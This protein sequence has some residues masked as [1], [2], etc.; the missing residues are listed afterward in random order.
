MSHHE[1]PRWRRYLRFW[2]PD[3][4]AD[5]DDEIRFHLEMLERDFLAAGLDPAAAREEALARFGDPDEVA[6][7]LRDHDT[8]KLR[9]SGAHRC[10]GDLLQDVRY[11]LRRL[12]Q[13]PGV[14]ARGRAGARA[15]HRRH[16]R[17]LRR[18]RRRA[19]ARAPVSRARASG[20]GRDLQGADPVPASFPEYHDWKGQYGRLRRA[21]RVLHHH[22]RADRRAASRSCCTRRGCRRTCRGCSAS[23]RASDARSRRPRTMP[24]PEGVVMIS[25]DL[26]RRRFGGDP[27][28]IGT[29]LTLAEEPYTVI[30]IVPRRPALD[31]ADRPARR[32]TA[33]RP[34]AVRCGSTT[35]DAPRGLHFLD[36][37]RA[38]SPALD[39]GGPQR[40]DRVVCAP[41]AGGRGDRPRHPARCA[42][43][44]R[45]RRIAA[46]PLRPRRR[47]GH[48]APHR[49]HQRGEPAARALGGATAR[50]R[51]PR[52][53]GRG[54]ARAWCGSCW[55]RACCSR[56]WAAPPACWSHGAP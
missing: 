44:P 42:G 31:R 14:H 26:W 48:A 53:A 36:V 35:D 23:C 51:R 24:R 41:A 25:E 43:S 15:R 4:A 6:R 34:L 37:S 21:R 32:G 16:D 54:R 56:C 52:G 47:R 29:T 38:S 33:S 17:D 50:D 45:G 9:R 10:A 46:P 3:V 13:A 5:V 11:G 55:S 49:V 39:L 8:R 7:W 30:G 12:W 28:I 1:Q 19:A 20:G 27:G 22:V 2:G 40:A 18:D